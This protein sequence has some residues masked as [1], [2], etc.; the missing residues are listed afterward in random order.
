MLNI[1]S[2]FIRKNL[3]FRLFLHIFLVIMLLASPKEIFLLV[4]LMTRVST[5]K[6]SIAKINI[7]KPK[8]LR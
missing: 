4:Q 8:R 3:T 6:G 1:A 7:K 5:I 2:F